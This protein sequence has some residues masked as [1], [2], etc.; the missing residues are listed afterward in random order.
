MV[1]PEGW[2]TYTAASLPEEGFIHASHLDQVVDTANRI[3]RGQTDLVILVIEAGRLTSRIETEEL[4]NYGAFPHV[5]GTIELD[6][7]VSTAVDFPRRFTALSSCLRES[8]KHS[9]FLSRTEASVS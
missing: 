2:P 4:Y 9:P 3:F 5:Y 7:V 6:A 8:R 1:P